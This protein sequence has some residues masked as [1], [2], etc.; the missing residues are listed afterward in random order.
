MKLKMEEITPGGLVGFL[1]GSKVSFGGQLL[2]WKIAFPRSSP[3][4]N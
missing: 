4:T 3:Q 2:H 1:N